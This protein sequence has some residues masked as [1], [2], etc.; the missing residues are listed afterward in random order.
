MQDF[1]P[2]IGARVLAFHPEARAWRPATVSAVLDERRARVHFAGYAI[3]EGSGQAGGPSEFEVRVPEELEPLDPC[4]DFL[5][6]AGES[7]R[8]AAWRGILQSLAIADP[9]VYGERRAAASLAEDPPAQR[10]LYALLIAAMLDEDA[11]IP[12]GAALLLRM[13]SLLCDGDP[14][15][16]ARADERQVARASRIMPSPLR[17]RVLFTNARRFL[18]LDSGEGGFLGWLG[19]QPDPVA[20]LCLSFDRLEPRAAVLFL[21]YLGMDAIAPDAALTRVAQRLGWV[22]RHPPPPSPEVRDTWRSLADEV[23]DRPALLDLTIRRFADVVCRIEPSCERCAV[24][25]CPSRRSDS[26][27]P[28]V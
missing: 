20:A 23:G 25:A 4:G 17:A 24:L 5:A 12:G 16:L 26:E 13:R 11:R 21:R 9:R 27:L 22:R 19:R 14:Q 10:D 1:R 15:A 18:E 3:D 8:A 7:A 6:E 2:T 28:P